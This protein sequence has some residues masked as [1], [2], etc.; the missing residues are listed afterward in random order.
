MKRKPKQ[1]KP[2]PDK[3]TTLRRYNL[4]RAKASKWMETA[5]IYF[6]DGALLDTARCCT[7]AAAQLF[8][9]Y[10]LRDQYLK[11]DQ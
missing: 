9:A 7:E 11:E 2:A 3:A 4:A 6:S 10:T 1:A 8:R 5:D